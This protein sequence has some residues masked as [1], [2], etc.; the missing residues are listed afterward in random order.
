MEKLHELRVRFGI[1]NY[2]AHY[3]NQPVT[4]EECSFRKAWLR[5]YRLFRKQMGFKV[6][7]T[8]IERTMLE[9][10]PSDS[11]SM[12]EDV[13]LSELTRVLILDPNHGGEKGRARHAAVVVGYRRFQGKKEIYLLQAW[14]KAV[15]HD[16]MAGNVKKIAER[17]HVERVFVETIA[18]QDGWLLYFERE[19][20]ASLPQTFV[21]ACP[22]ERGAGAKERRILSMS[23]LYERGQV[24]VPVTGAED[25]L[26]EY[27]YHP[28]GTTV[29]LIDA[30]G[31]LFN[32][33]E[34]QEVDGALWKRQF[35]MDMER[36]RRSIGSAGY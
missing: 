35:G 26:H 12:L 25:F 1:R 20:R 30:M 34:T 23:P 21:E 15:S 31:Y 17:W 3:L 28:N 11:N 2:S 22:K 36:R 32:I 7:G 19:L 5:K 29:D 14:A 4:E 10:I 16:Q 24:W 18:G 6:D 27:E 8:P 9:R 13:P 33:V